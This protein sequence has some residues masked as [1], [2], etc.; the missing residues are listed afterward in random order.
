MDVN[1]LILMLPSFVSIAIFLLILIDKDEETKN[2]IEKPVGQKHDYN[3]EKDVQYLIF[4]VDYFC[5]VA[6][7]TKLVPYQKG[8]NGNNFINDN[9]FN[10]IVLE[11]TRQVVKYLSVSYREVLSYYIPNI[12]DFVAELVYNKII[13]MTMELNRETIRKISKII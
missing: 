2:Q 8:N 7:S 13:E 1:V 4:I 6:Y 12:T 10:D 9:V 3:F 11:T 5:K